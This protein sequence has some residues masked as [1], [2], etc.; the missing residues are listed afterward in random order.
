MS[1]LAYDLYLEVRKR[2]YIGDCIGEYY[3]GS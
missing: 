3:R 2:G 1:F